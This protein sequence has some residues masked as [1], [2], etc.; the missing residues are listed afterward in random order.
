MLVFKLLTFLVICLC[1]GKFQRNWNIK[2]NYSL[3]DYLFL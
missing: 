3:Y 1:K 2:F